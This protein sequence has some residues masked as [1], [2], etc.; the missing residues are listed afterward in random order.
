MSNKAITELLSSNVRADVEGDDEELRESLKEFGWVKELPALA[1]ENGVVLVGNRRVRLAKELGIEPNIRTITFGNG[2]AADA[3]RVRLAIASNIGGKPMSPKDRQ[4]I[5]RHLY[6]EHQWTMQRIGDALNVTHKT[7]SKD[8]AGFVPEVQISRPKGGRPKREARSKAKT[9]RSKAAPAVQSSPAEFVSD[10]DSR[11][12][13]QAEAR[14]KRIAHADA[15]AAEIKG[16]KRE[17][18]HLKVHIKQLERE[19]DSLNHSEGLWRLR[20]EQAG[21]EPSMPD[22]SGPDRQQQNDDGAGP[23]AD[24]ATAPTPS[25]TVSGTPATAAAR[26]S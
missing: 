13:A 14:D 15:L 17:N 5:A 10:P 16:L 24:S 8:L 6:G 12:E 4:R 19:I 2:D 20:A 1:D 22:P 21:W 26:R 23:H 18:A 11:V 9:R 3:E 25:T 7:I